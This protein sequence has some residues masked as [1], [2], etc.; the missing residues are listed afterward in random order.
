MVIAATSRSTTGTGTDAT[1]YITTETISPASDSLVLIWVFSIVA[2]GP[3]NIP[4]PAGYTQVLS[5]GDNANL[6]RLTLLRAMGLAPGQVTFDFAG[7]TQTGCAW[8]IVEFTGVDTTGTNGSGAIVQYKAGEVA[9]P[10]T[11]MSLTLDAPV[12]LGNTSAGAF[13]HSQNQTKTVG[14]GYTLIANRNQTSPNIGLASE[15]RTDGQALID[16]SWLT[17]SLAIGIGVE[18]KASD[19]VSIFSPG[20]FFALF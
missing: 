4:A 14:T 1:S 12:T 13:Y 10:A 18:I 15:Y 3:A 16:M 19:L 8:S 2:S 11:S 17:G 9:S 5:Y 20:A 7:Q 6:R